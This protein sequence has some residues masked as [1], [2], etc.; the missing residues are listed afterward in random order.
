ML[1]LA[2]S[3]QVARAQLPNGARLPLSMRSG[4]QVSLSLLCQGRHEGRGAAR[5]PEGGH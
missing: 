2:S 4:P 5:R 1:T 3:G